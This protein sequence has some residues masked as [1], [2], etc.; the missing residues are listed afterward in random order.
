MDNRETPEYEVMLTEEDELEVN[1]EEHDMPRGVSEAEADTGTLSDFKAAIASITPKFASKRQ[2]DIMQPIMVG[3]IP[4]EN[5]LDL[6][7]LTNMYMIEELEGEED[8]DFLAIVTGN[9][10]GISIGF[11]GRGIIDRAEMYGA[12][13]ESEMERLSKDLGL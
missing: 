11:E 4:P 1:L 12:A 2:N 10:V 13:R 6:N 3:R 5:V 7:Y 9:Q 8:I